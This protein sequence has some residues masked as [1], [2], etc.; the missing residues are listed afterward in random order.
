MSRFLS[1]SIP[2]KRSPIRPK[3]IS[4]SAAVILGMLKSLKA[5]IKIAYSEIF[6]SA[7]LK[8]PA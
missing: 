4:K 2:G 6:G 5:L 7:L 1:A 3:K 8:E